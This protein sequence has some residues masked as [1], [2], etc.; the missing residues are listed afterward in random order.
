MKTLLAV[1]L[2]VFVRGVLLAVDKALTTTS[3]F[4]IAVWKDFKA[5]KAETTAG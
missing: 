2:L 3:H 1:F 4:D 5:A